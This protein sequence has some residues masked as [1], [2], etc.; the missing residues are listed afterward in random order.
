MSGAVA[1]LEHDVLRAIATAAGRRTPRPP[2]PGDTEP[3]LTRYGLRTPQVHAIIRALRP[4]VRA[5]T[6]A[7]RLA[8]A[9][10]LYRSGAIE[11]AA[12]ATAVV[13]SVVDRLEPRHV[14]HLDRFFDHVRGWG[15]T[16]D[17]CINVLGPLL[18][19]SPLALLPLLR[20]WTRSPNRWKRRASVV[21]FTRKVGASGRFTEEVLRLCGRLIWDPDR[22]VQQGVGWALKDTLRGDRARVYPYIRR[23][24]AIGAPATITLYAMRDL[25]G[26]EREALLRVR[27]ST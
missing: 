23:L 14:A 7:Q 4:R 13:A 3:D 21:A 6:L 11:P 9:G 10:R 17:L 15:T 18:M 16:D 25:R 5:L 12:V 1:A 24:R 8:L 2:R 27:P 22:L 19:R 20:R 26:P